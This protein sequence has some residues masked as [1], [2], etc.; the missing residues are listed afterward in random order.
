MII[1][2][3][4]REDAYEIDQEIEIDENILKT[5]DIKRISKVLVKG[6]LYKIGEGIFEIRV[7]V[8]GIM[9][10]LCA[11]SLEEVE[12]PFNININEPLEQIGENENNLT[13]SIDIFPIIWENIVLEIP[14]RIVKDDIKIETSGDG[15]S[16][17]TDEDSGNKA[18]SDLKYIDMEEER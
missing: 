6:S 12:Y 11:L 15:W 2:I 1:E 17:T 10:L 9:T 13:N 4:S 16:L 5:T 7:N 14:A 18:L 8:S 3:N